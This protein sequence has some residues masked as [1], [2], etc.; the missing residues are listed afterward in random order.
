MFY[1]EAYTDAKR[2]SCIIEVGYNCSFSP[3]LFGGGARGAEGA[4]DTTPYMVTSL[5]YMVITLII[6]EL[7]ALIFIMEAI[8][9]FRFQIFSKIFNPRRGSRDS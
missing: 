9:T 7:F 2:N 3:T 8:L 1:P 4:G 6:G 5:P